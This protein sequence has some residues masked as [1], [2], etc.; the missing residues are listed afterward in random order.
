LGG[1][2]DNVL[3]CKLREM[4]Q[5]RLETLKK[6]FAAKVNR[7]TPR[8][9]K[10][11]IWEDVTVRIGL[12]QGQG[13][14][15]EKA[16]FLLWNKVSLDLDRPSN[17]I[18]TTHG[19]VILDE[20]FKGRIYLKGLILEGEGGMPFKYCYNFY[21][22]EVNRDRERL[23]YPKQEAN[24]L[25]EIWAEAVTL[26]EALTLPHLMEMLQAD[27]EWADV[28]LVQDYISKETAGK[29]WKRFQDQN[30]EGKLFYYYDQNG[31]KVRDPL[32]FFNECSFLTFPTLRFI[33]PMQVNKTNDILGHRAHHQKFTERACPIEEGSLAVFEKVPT[34]QYT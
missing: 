30:M 9:L 13:R 31:D 25:A 17:I 20:R 8:D 12:F 16:E 18:S 7:G 24:T 4:S 14:R 5:G 26:D 33:R 11:N 23:I 3:Y 6:N 29:I 22:G 21:R 2:D 34:C 15:V 10:G 27:E 28:N 1:R 19:S 32:T